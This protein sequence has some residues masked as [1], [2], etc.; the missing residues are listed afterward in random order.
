MNHPQSFTS[1]GSGWNIGTFYH[2]DW[3]LLVG[4]IKPKFFK[5]FDLSDLD[6]IQAWNI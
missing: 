6:L 4:Y 5:N 1:H 2:F 3:G